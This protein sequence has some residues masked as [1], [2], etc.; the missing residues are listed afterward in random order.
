[1]LAIM[2]CMVLK[3]A[4]KKG[5]YKFQGSFKPNVGVSNLNNFFVVD[6]STKLMNRRST[7]VKPILNGDNKS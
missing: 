2:V 5:I 6:K 4:N 3:I 7:E 1:M